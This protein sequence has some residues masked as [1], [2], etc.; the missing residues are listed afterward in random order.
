M[1]EGQA[2]VLVVVVGAASWVAIMFAIARIGGWS[3]LARVYR[4]SGRFHGT[5]W[6]CEFFAMRYYCGYGFVTVGASAQGLSLSLPALGGLQGHPPLFVPWA[7]VSLAEPEHMRA[8][9]STELRFRR[10]PDVRVR[11]SSALRARL[12]SVH[13]EL[14]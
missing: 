1:S 3:D 5:R 9:Y 4:A 14:R 7:D 12:E 6:R 8:F 11:I 2:L 10:V 13:S